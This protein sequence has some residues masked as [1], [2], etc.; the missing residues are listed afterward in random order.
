MD[1]KK[2][3]FNYTYSASRQMEIKRIR[4]K[5]ISPTQEETKMEQLRR[6]DAGVTKK[7]TFAAL[8]VGILGCLILEAGM[9][10]VMVWGGSLFF[11]GVIVGII[12][13]AAVAAAYPLYLLVIKKER[14]R[15]APEI[16]KLSDELS[17]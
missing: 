4:E 1:E 15:I 14:A 3:T 7:G 8:T 13:L 11:V 10:C 17:K 2:E 6:L 5:Y 9:S 16:L 12:G